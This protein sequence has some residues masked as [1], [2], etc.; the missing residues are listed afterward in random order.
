MRS[1]IV[2]VPMQFV[3]Y[4]GLVILQCDLSRDSFVAAFNLDDGAKVWSTPRDAAHVVCVG[5]E[6]LI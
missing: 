3:L 5:D 4:E 6:H 2:C 1:V